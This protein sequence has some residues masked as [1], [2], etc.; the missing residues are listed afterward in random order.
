MA[1]NNRKPI[2]KHE[3]LL[4]RAHKDIISMITLPLQLP[5]EANGWCAICLCTLIIE[6]D[7]RERTFCGVGDASPMNS[8]PPQQ[9]YLPRFSETRAEVRA[10][11]KAYNI[12]EYAAEEMNDYAGE[13]TTGTERTPR[14]GAAGAR[15]NTSD[16][17]CACGA[18]PGG[19][20]A[21]ACTALKVVAA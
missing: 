7:G 17:K 1:Q 21:T 13:K 15:T 11:R 10:L 3:T 6:R 9:K 2:I 14:T 4:A 19:P 5:S 20:H 18:P 12:A 16:K 8:E